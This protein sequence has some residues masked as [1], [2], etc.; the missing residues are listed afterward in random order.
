MSLAEFWNDPVVEAARDAYRA[1]AEAYADHIERYID[2]AIRERF[3]SATE[4]RV[5]GYSDYD[6]GFIVRVQEVRI[7][8]VVIVSWESPD[9]ETLD[10]LFEELSEE[11][12]PLL[13]LLGDLTGDDYEGDDEP[14]ILNPP[15]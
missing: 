4:L 5:K 12:D 9:D 6:S 8:D 1:A 2:A 11:I 13:D 10:A 14:Y 7:D 15:K 3:P